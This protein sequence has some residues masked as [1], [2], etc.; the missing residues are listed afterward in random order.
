MSVLVIEPINNNWF[1]FLILKFFFK[2]LRLITNCPSRMLANSCTKKW[3]LLSSTKHQFWKTSLY[4]VHQILAR[5]AKTW[6]KGTTQP[7]HGFC[8]CQSNLRTG[9]WNIK[10]KRGFYLIFLFR[11]FAK[12]IACVSSVVVVSTQPPLLMVEARWWCP[13]PRPTRSARQSLGRALLQEISV[14]V[15]SQPW[16]RSIQSSLENTTD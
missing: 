1:W 13:P 15:S 5:S 6:T 16:Q 2:G 7:E 8:G 12:L 14:L 11:T 3:S 9:K 4:C 10:K